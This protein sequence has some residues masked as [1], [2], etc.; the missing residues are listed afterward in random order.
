MSKGKFCLSIG[1]Q[2]YK[3]PKKK[4]Q[5]PQ[6]EKVLCREMIQARKYSRFCIDQ[7]VARIH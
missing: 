6:L 4:V 5:R 7:I 2:N 3:S 1:H